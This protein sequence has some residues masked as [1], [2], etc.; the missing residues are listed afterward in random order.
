M[1]SPA[2]LATLARQW[3]ERGL[4]CE[5]IDEVKM[6]E[7]GMKGILSVGSGSMLTE[8]IPSTA[9]KVLPGIG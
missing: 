2:E 6:G 4:E 1:I 9:P 8:V 3:P 7:M 5:I